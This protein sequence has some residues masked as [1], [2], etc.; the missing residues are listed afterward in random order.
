MR[1]GFRCHHHAERRRAEQELLEGAVGVVAGE[2][3]RKREHRGEERGDPDH[4]R[5]D[6]AEQVRLGADAER[7]K[8]RHDDEEEERGGDIAAPA[9]REQQ[10]AAHERAARGEDQSCTTRACASMPVG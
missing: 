10:L 5:R 9:Q 6:R 1:E 3:A 2:K 8:A 7:K 4:A